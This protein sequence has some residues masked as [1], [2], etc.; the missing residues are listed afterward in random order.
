MSFKKDS[1]NHIIRK[2]LYDVIDLLSYAGGLLGLIAGFSMLSFFE[3][4]YWFII[5]AAVKNFHRS[6]QVFPLN[7]NLDGS[8]NFIS[9]EVITQDFLK[10]TSIHGLRYVTKRNIIDR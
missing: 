8:N 9:F 10:N 2:E 7:E 6:T 5:R 3:L 4:V 1:I